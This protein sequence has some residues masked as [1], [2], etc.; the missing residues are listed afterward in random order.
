MAGGKIQEL[1]DV[2]IVGGGAA[3]LVTAIFAARRRPEWT[4]TILD[5]ARHLGAKIL[6]AGGGRCNVTNRVVSAADFHGGSP[7]VIKRILA[8]FPA[9]QT[10]AFFR[11]IG[12]ELHEEEHGKLFPDTNRARSVLDALL[13]EADRCG[14]HI[15]TDHRVLSIERGE[16][17]FRIETPAATLTA[18]HVVLA[19]GGRSLPKTGSDGLGYEL[20]RALGHTLI[21]T[22]PALVPLLLAGEFHAPLSGISQ[23]VE[24]TVSATGT[25]PVRVRGALL[26]THFGISGPAVLDVS[27]HWH[28]A[29][30]EQR[31][32]SVTVNFLPGDDFAAA[33]QRL[34]AAVWAQPR[35]VLR[36]LLA[37]WLPV[38][39]ADAMATALGIT[40]MLP[41]AHLSKEIR[42]KLIHAL[43]AWPLPVIDSRGYSHAE[44]TAGG[45]PMNEIDPTTMASRVCPGL[46]LAGEILDV[47]GRIGGFNFQW[48]WS[49][50]WVAAAGLAQRDD[51]EQAE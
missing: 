50:G 21:P 1:V 43:I 30:L 46:F 28:R 44:A 11:E 9:E 13:S 19:T 2:A 18:R 17:G 26:W 37:R 32:V 38:R 41:M 40:R 22:T 42:R 39:V 34:L 36:G 5:G 24:L 20:A 49:S 33:E 23:D 6:V 45:V 8:A 29:R 7:H 4:V 47:D 51:R 10:A 31:E 12:V 15:R 35:A 3:G 27:R 14:V 48:A 16:A 25:K